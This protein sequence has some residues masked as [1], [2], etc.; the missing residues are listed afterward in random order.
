[1]LNSLVRVTRRARWLVYHSTTDCSTP[2][3]SRTRGNAEPLITTR[4]DGPPANPHLAGN[5]TARPTSINSRAPH[6]TTPVTCVPDTTTARGFEG[7]NERTDEADRTDAL[8][9]HLHHRSPPSHQQCS[10]STT[11]QQLV[12]RK[13]TISHSS[14]GAP[15]RRP[16]TCPRPCP[17]DPSIHPSASQSAS[18]PVSR[19]AN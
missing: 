3:T 18:Q 5:T 9:S 14:T 2:G 7:T 11:Q 12:D 6:P 17:P 13:R 19:E 15:L 1:M 8:H 16:L 4:D 10:H